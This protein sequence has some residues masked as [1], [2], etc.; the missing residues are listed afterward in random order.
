MPRYR[1]RWELIPR[2]LARELVDQLRLPG[3]PTATLQSEYGLRPRDQ[4]VRDCWPVLR[5]SWLARD[6]GWRRFVVEELRAR[7]LGRADAPAGTKAQQMDYLRSCRNADSL[8]AIVLA[9]FHQLGDISH[10]E[11]RT[12]ITD[13]SLS[14]EGEMPGTAGKVWRGDEPLSSNLDETLV[15][16]WTDFTDRLSRLLARLEEGQVV[17]LELPSPY[18]RSEIEGA[19]PYVEFRVTTDGMLTGT[20]PGRDS[21]D[22]R[23]H[24]SAALENQLLGTGWSQGDDDPSGSCAFS[25]ATSLADVLVLA[26]KTAGAI[27]D[28]FGV[29][30]PS[31]LTA[32]GF[33]T[34]PNVVSPTVDLGVPGIP[35]PFRA[36]R[37]DVVAVPDSADHLIQLVD[38]TMT[39]LFGHPPTRDSDGD[40]PIRSG[41]AM[42]FVR[43]LLDAP[44]V[45]LFA[46]LLLDVEGTALTLERLAQI[47]QRVRFVK[48][49]WRSG[50]V[51]ADMQL[52]CIPF[53]GAHLRHAVALM[54]EVADRADD[55]LRL[56]VGG[57]LFFAQ[58]PDRGVDQQDGLPPELLTL[59]HLDPHGTGEVEPE[60]AASVCNWDRDLIL[61]FIRLSEEEML[62][63]LRSAERAAQ[64]GDE[65]E[66]AA[67]HHEETAWQATVDLLRAALRVVVG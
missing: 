42:V 64:H 36:D 63:W 27:R 11:G 33:S 67:C 3:E 24:L 43:V 17:I 51:F 48:F 16:A 62:S 30:H 56:E 58:D 35:M 44:I 55:E 59:L 25:M 45:E 47:N 26:E 20:L 15:R 49:T 14:D 66:A 40:I 41:S 23:H 9:A 50:V 52:H 34:E 28:S 65:E 21:F 2:R 38:E 10:G 57:R 39:S 54:S 19:A 31:F 1:F 46:P 32:V 8:R 60:L 29:P 4:F 7:G 61:D 18:D 5:D 6:G 22:E 13:I 37:P 53:V 12:D